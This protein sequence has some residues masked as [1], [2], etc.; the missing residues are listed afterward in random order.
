MSRGDASS[1]SLKSDLASCRSVSLVEQ[2]YFRLSPKKNW[3]LTYFLFSYTSY[4]YP[5]DFWIGPIFV[6]SYANLVPVRY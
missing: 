2:L 4:T 5:T 3:P 1:R 6:R